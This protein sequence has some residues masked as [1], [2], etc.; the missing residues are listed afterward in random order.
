VD[1]FYLNAQRNPV[2]AGDHESLPEGPHLSFARDAMIWLLL[3]DR[4]ARNE[5]TEVP[6]TDNF[7]PVFIDIAWV[8]ID[9][10]RRRKYGSGRCMAKSY[11]DRTAGADLL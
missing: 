8:Y 6:N 11:P 1:S 4:V 3:P 10:R 9:Y 7:I 2:F 5:W